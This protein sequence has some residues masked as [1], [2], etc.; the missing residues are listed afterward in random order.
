MFK[1]VKVDHSLEKTS[2]NCPLYALKL[3][4]HFIFR[5]FR[6]TN[7]LKQH[8]IHQVRPLWSLNDGNDQVHHLSSPTNSTFNAVLNSEHD[9]NKHDC[10]FGLWFL[11]FAYLFCLNRQ[12]IKETIRTSPKAEPTSMGTNKPVKHGATEAERIKLWF[13]SFSPCFHFY[14]VCVCVWNFKIF[15]QE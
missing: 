1:S 15:E 4:N 10:G 3:N 7:V 12:H 6:H 14:A 2:A 9:F 11:A 5:R 13:V 8:N